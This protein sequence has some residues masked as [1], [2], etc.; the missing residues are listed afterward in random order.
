M[1]VLCTLV[2]ATSGL[3]R[4]TAIESSHCL[5]RACHVGFTKAIRSPLFRFTRDTLPPCD[6]PYTTFGSVGSMAA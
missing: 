1:A 6:S 2:A 5:Y 4:T 3:P